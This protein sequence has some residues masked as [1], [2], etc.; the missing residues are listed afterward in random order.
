[1]VELILSHV[2]VGTP[3]EDASRFMEREGFECS[4]STDAE[5]PDR[6]RD[7][8]YCNRWESIGFLVSRRWHVSIAYRDGKVTEVTAS[9]GLVGP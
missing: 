5:V 3:I 9:T 2:P 4:R 8:L 6:K 7:Y 1:M